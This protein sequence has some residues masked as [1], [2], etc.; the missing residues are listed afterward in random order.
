MSNLRSR[1]RR[2]AKQITKVYQKEI[3]SKDLIDTG[4]LFRSFE[5]KINVS[6]KGDIQI[7]VKTKV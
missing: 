1:I 5:T 6:K 3:K 4:N 2:L 7:D